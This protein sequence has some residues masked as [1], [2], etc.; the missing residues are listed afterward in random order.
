MNLF[1]SL[2]LQRS[3][4]APRCSLLSYILTSILISLLFFCSCGNNPNPISE[5]QDQV[6]KD[7]YPEELPSMHPANGQQA[8]FDNLSINRTPRFMV[9]SNCSLYDAVD[10]QRGRIIL[11]GPN[12]LIL[13][14]AIIRDNA[15]GDGG[16]HGP[17]GNIH[18]LLLDESTPNPSYGDYRCSSDI[19]DWIDGHLIG[20]MVLR[21]E[22]WTGNKYEWLDN[23]CRDYKNVGLYQ[24]ASIQNRPKLKIF[25]YESDGGGCGPSWLWYR[26]HDLLLWGLIDGNMIESGYLRLDSQLQCAEDVVR[27]HPEFRDQPK[28]TLYFQI[29]KPKPRSPSQYT[30]FS[31][32]RVELDNEN[33]RAFL[34]VDLDIGG[35]LGQTKAIGG[36]WAKMCGND[37]CYVPSKC[38]L[39][40]PK[41]YV[42]YLWDI[43]PSYDNSRFTGLGFWVSYECFPDRSEGETYYG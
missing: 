15:E 32:L 8:A 35:Y 17:A 29:T 16:V 28:I 2:A 40:T 10:D 25:V 5:N 41:D 24:Y 12:S 31:N 37:Y 34:F 39:T 30:K 23:Q 7:D 36:Y 14:R 1:L 6:E 43:T 19:N 13:T 3:K 38:E 9:G 27:K 20:E 4:S 18:V 11:G 26:H 22:T 21:G 33:K 42:G